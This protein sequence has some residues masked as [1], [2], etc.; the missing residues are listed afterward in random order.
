MLESTDG[1]GTSRKY[2]TTPCD[3]N[4]EKVKQI[5][6]TK[7]ASGWLAGDTEELEEEDGRR[8]QS[9]SD[10]E[11]DQL[12]TPSQHNASNNR[13]KRIELTTTISHES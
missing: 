11:L 5:Y 8:R 2:P 6:T 13:I 7:F 3:E 1:G 4:A 12:E 10:T 9:W